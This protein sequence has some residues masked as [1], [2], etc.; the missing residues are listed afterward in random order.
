MTLTLGS[1]P[2]GPNTTG[3]FNFRRE[4]PAH[5]LYWEDWPRRMR[6]VVAGETVLDSRRGKALHE[7]GLLPV[8][9]FPIE[10]LCQ[11][12][13]EPSDHRTT[14]PFKG[15]ASYWSVRAGGTFVENAVWSYPDP[16]D[17]AP[18]LAGYAA[19]YF[20]RMDSWFEEDQEV[21]AHPR[22]PYHRVDVRAASRHVVVRH[23]DAV[24][25]E[26]ERPQLL[27]ETGLPVRYYLP[28]GDVRTALLK[29]SDTV[30]QC[31]YK[32][33]GQHWHLAADGA[34]GEDGADSSEISDVAWSLPRA[35]PEAVEADGHFCFYP[36]KVT[37]EVDGERVGP[38]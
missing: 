10:D 17:G 4:G 30:S 20:D 24:V 12:L 33:E 21:Y 13:L 35:L 16:I 19:L 32:G 25:A 11:E 2:F 5:V 34:E 37:V 23:G 29:K 15:E 8:H 36:D 26:S 1:G 31:P 27:F 3:R 38:E 7:T 14:C 28:A 6:A 22:D 18:P 9:Y